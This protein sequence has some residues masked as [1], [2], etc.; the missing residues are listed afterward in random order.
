MIFRCPRDR[1]L[2]PL[3]MVEKVMMT[4]L[5]QRAPRQAK[6]SKECILFTYHILSYPSFARGNCVP[7]STPSR[8][9]ASS[10]GSSSS[11]HASF[12]PELPANTP[13]DRW[14][15][16]TS[17][18]PLSDNWSVAS[19]ARISASS[20]SSYGFSAHAEYLP[21]APQLTA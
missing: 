10:S 21:S 7:T 14:N 3:A 5:C 12:C 16:F 19:Y 9:A 13:D 11:S 6:V 18:S 2:T 1:L 17:A 20:A 8:P 4:F 15:T